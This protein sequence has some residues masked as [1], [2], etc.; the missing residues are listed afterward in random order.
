M[1]NYRYYIQNEPKS[2]RRFTDETA[3]R[4]DSGESKWTSHCAKEET[5]ITT[6]DKQ[7]SVAEAHEF[8][9]TL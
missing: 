8:I 2:I 7:V 4:Y 1:S 9:N 6:R 3:E 5:C